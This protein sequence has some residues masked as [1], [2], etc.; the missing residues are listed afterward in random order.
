MLSLL[1]FYQ[2]GEFIYLF[3]NILFRLIKSLLL[4]EIFYVTCMLVPVRIIDIFVQWKKDDFRPSEIDRVCN[5]ILP[6][7]MS[8]MV[9]NFYRSITIISQ[10]MLEFIFEKI[11]RLLNIDY[12]GAKC[13]HVFSYL[14]R[15]ILF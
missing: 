13:I 8:T 15:F 5:A 14:Q 3:I 7:F 1:S 4:V 10:D 12:G 9:K 11:Q 2:K 6:I